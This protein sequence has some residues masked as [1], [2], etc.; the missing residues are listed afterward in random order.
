MRKIRIDWK[1]LAAAAALAI[2]APSRAQDNASADPVIDNGILYVE[3][4]FE[5]PTAPEELKEFS[6][7]AIG[8]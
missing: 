8:S 5:Y 3:P 1:I 4:L 6:E 2:W 7:N